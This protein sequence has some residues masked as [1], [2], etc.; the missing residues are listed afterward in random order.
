MKEEKVID[1]QL[2]TIVISIV[3]TIVSLLLTY[4]Q[5]LE[6]QN[7]K[8]LFSPKN[9][10]KITKINRI[11]ILIVSI[12]FLYVN[13]QLY[14]ISKKEGENLTPYKLQI[15]S[16][17]LVTIAGIITLYVILSSERETVADVENPIV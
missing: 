12:I 2:Y 17:I 9:T 4:N 16:S 6:Q 8:T 11:I 10:L 14:E 3:T 5:K 1:I 13:Y 7:K 15:L